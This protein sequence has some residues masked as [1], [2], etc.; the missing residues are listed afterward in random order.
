[1]PRQAQEST[2]FELLGTPHVSERVVKLWVWEGTLRESVRPTLHMTLQAFVAELGVPNDGACDAGYADYEL[3]GAAGRSGDGYLGYTFAKPQ[4]GAGDLLLMTPYK[5][6]QTIWPRKEWHPILDRLYAIRGE[7]REGSEAL[8]TFIY[9]S[10][11]G[12]F[13]APLLKN[14]T[15]TLDRL[16]LYP[17]I[18][19]PTEVIVREYL[20]SRP[21]TNVQVRTPVPTLVQYSYLGMQNSLV[22]LHPTVTV[23]ELIKG[24]KLLEGFGTPDP[25]EYGAER[26]IVFPETNFTTWEPHIYDAEYEE[27]GGVYYLKTYEALPPELPDPQLL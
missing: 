16:V 10:D 6:P 18:T 20:S 25:Q 13:G 17:G 9:T 14:K 21:F 2:H 7:A 4:T 24:G 1:M 8:D 3:T 23:P 19:C 11:A 27:D 12:N 26:G 5:D 15:L 22:C